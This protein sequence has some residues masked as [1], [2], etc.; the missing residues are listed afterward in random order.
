MLSFVPQGR[1]KGL[2]EDILK[3]V[4]MVRPDPAGIN[5]HP[6]RLGEQ[7][8]VGLATPERREPEMENQTGTAL[9]VP[10]IHN[11]LCEK[12]VLGRRG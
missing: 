5:W 9:I 11:H 1:G 10:A 3:I 7:V 2:P 8:A 6:R 4:G 12:R